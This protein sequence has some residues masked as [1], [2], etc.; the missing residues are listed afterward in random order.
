MKEACEGVRDR[1]GAVSD[2]LEQL[3]ERLAITRRC[4]DGMRRIVAALPRVMG[5]KPGRLAR[6]ETY[7][8]VLDVAEAER[9]ADGHSP[10]AASKLR[11]RSSRRPPEMRS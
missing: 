1:A 3:I 9:L 2:Y 7:S 11:A 8:L 5:G 10:R 6:S 4:A